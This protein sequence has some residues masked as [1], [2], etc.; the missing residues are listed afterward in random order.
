V[1]AVKLGARQSGGGRGPNLVGTG[2]AAIRTV[3]DERAHTVFY[4]SRIIQTGSNLK[5]ENRC[6]TLLQTFPF[7]YVARVDIM[8]NFLNY[9]DIQFPTELELKILEQ[10]QYLSFDEF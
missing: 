1:A 8:N 5:I 10:I 7:L 2:G 3:A 9:T 6:F 4:F